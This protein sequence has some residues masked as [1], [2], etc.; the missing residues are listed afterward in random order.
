MLHDIARLGSRQDVFIGLETLHGELNEF[1]Q[2]EL[3]PVMILAK[4][5]YKSLKSAHTI[6]SE[7][8]K[9]GAVLD[10]RNSLGY[11]ALYYAV[12]THSTHAVHSLLKLGASPNMSVNDACSLLHY[13]IRTR[14]VAI[15]RLLFKHTSEEYLKMP[16][17]FTGNTILHDM[18]AIKYPF[19]GEMLADSVLMRMVETPNRFGETPFGHAI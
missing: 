5:R 14:N 12:E 6:F 3:T 17:R 13:S 7:C 11:T 16:D 9:F 8:V 19:I 1:N 18:K 2:N 4:R 10:K 15:I